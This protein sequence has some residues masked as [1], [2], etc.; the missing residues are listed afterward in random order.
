MLEHFF[1]VFL[2]SGIF[3]DF[4]GYYHL[5]TPIDF[6]L[7]SAI[8]ALICLLLKIIIYKKCK[9]NLTFRNRLVIVSFLL[10]WFWMLISLLYS[11]SPKYSYIKTLLFSTNFIT[12]IIVAVGKLETKKV[13]KYFVFYT[14]FFLILYIPI[15]LG[16]QNNTISNE[17]LKSVGG[18]Y[19][20]LGLNLGII[21]LIL[22]FSSS[23]IFNFKADTYI[24]YLSFILLVLIGARGP[25][26]FTIIIYILYYLFSL[27]KLKKIRLQFS[28]KKLI[29]SSIA[30]ISFSAIIIYYFNEIKVLLVR[31]L[32]RLALIISHDKGS[33]INTRIEHFNKSLELLQNP[34]IFIKGIGIGSY[35]FVT[36]HIDIRGYPHNILLE[37]WVELGI[38]G[39][40]LFLLICF[41]FLSVGRKSRYIS[42]YLFLYLFL[43]LLTSSS[44]VDIRLTIGFFM[45]FN[46]DENNLLEINKIKDKVPDER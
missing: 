11:H 1:V 17:S 7:F 33:S 18:L 5:D 6:T 41:S 15:L 4:F 21:V 28:F 37:I 23:T 38:I 16:F 9:I 19:L 20:T 30:L 35:M 42:I 22:K 40:L 45:L 26:V 8:V 24:R 13:I 14:Y 32:S 43:N 12:I 46:E 34:V 10:F 29:I 31:S 39:L 25:L 36:Q 44:L 27:V 2:I 3:K